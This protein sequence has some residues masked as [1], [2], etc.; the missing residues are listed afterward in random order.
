MKMWSTSID[1]KEG[2]LKGASSLSSLSSPWLGPD[3]GD[4]SGDIFCVG[5]DAFLVLLEVWVHGV[6]VLR[7]VLGNS[8]ECSFLE[9]V[10]GIDFSSSSQGLFKPCMHMQACQSLSSL[11]SFLHVLSDSGPVGHLYHSIIAYRM[12][13]RIGS[14][15]ADIPFS[16]IECCVWH[17]CRS[18]GY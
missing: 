5:D 11:T 10:G 14:I 8:D 6:G 9:M 16:M 13:Y 18:S 1:G 7:F 17:A 12:F 3:F 15:A 2:K 4:V